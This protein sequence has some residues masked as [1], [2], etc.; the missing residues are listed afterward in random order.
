MGL[1]RGFEPRLQDKASCV[2]TLALD[3]AIVLY[4]V[5]HLNNHNIMW[6]TIGSG[7][8]NEITKYDTT[9]HHTNLLVIVLSHI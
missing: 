3:H 2:L 6:S 4:S 1:A 9:L 8:N 5:I 7:Y